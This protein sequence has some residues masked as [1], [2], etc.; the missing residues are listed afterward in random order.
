MEAQKSALFITNSYFAANIQ[1]F[2]ERQTILREKVLILDILKQVTVI[3]INLSFYRNNVRARNHNDIGLILGF[4][5][6]RIR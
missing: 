4:Y 1:L 5:G 6:D 3:R 2:S